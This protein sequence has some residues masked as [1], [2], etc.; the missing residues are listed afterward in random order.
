MTLW[1][2][3]ARL[4]ALGTLVIWAASCSLFGG[5]AI[6][7]AAC[8]ALRADVDA[9]RASYATQ[10]QINAKI[11]TFVQATKDIAAVSARIEAEAA[12]ACRRMG[13]DLG[14]SPQQMAARSNR[15]GAQADGACQALAARID[16]ILQQGVVVHAVVTPPACQA[17]AQAHAHCAGAC[18]VNQDAECAASCK[19]HAEV[20]AGCT[21]AAVVVT[22]SQGAHLAMQLVAT[23]QANL[24]QLIHAQITLGR[25]LLREAQ[26]VAEIGVR[27]PKMMGQA[28]A[29]AIACVGAAADVAAAA[30]LRIDVSV[31]ASASVSGRAGVG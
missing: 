29:Q 20:H 27:L 12:A 7:T 30:S 10:V 14:L 15:P 21:P 17:N 23:L 16:G 26:V 28:G 31:R 9:L 6:G 1:P 24:P 13:A 11:R 3:L 8:P 5:S 4:L 22:A 25:R 2:R 19:A 18:D